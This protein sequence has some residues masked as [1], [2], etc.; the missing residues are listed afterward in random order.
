MRYPAILVLLNLLSASWAVVTRN[1]SEIK[2]K[3]LEDEVIAGDTLPHMEITFA[4]GS[5]DE[6]FL[7]PDSE[8][9]CF[10]HGSLKSDIESEV[11]ED[12]CKDNVEIIVISSRLV[13]C[14]L[15]ILLLENGKTYSIDP[16]E[17]RENLNGT[18]LVAPPAAAAFQGAGFQGHQLP[19]SVVA[20]IHVKFDQSLVN[21]FGSRAL[22]ERRVKAIV[23]MSRA[24]FHRSSGLA[25]DVQIEVLSWEFTPRTIP[26]PGCAAGTTTFGGLTGNGDGHPVA[27]FRD[28][29]RSCET[30]KG[31]TVGVA[32]VAAFCWS[33][34]AITAQYPGKSLTILYKTIN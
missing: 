20:K 32:Q 28:W 17:G 21:Q 2:L 13:P 19:M 1:P 9:E 16:S 5:K 22:A 24:W 15:V 33:N 25:M 7:E 30:T 27:W 14:G 11:E 18:D 6:V 34:Q 29:P 26:C 3:W 23:H 10:F 12:G 4:D 31:V 8:I